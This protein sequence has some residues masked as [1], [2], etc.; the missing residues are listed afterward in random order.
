[1][2]QATHTARRKFQRSGGHLGELRR[3]EWEA[4]EGTAAYSSQRKENGEKEKARG[5]KRNE[6]QKRNRIHFSGPRSLERTLKSTNR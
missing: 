3:Q 5:R 1:M 6:K 2:V 4:G